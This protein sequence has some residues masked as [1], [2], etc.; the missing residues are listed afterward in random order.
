MS[1]SPFPAGSEERHLYSSAG[2]YHLYGRRTYSSVT[3][4]RRQILF[5]LPRNQ[6]EF[7]SAAPISYRKF[8]RDLEEAIEVNSTIAKAIFTHSIEAFD[9]EESILQGKEWLDI[10]DDNSISK[11]QSMIKQLYRE[12]SA[13]GAVERDACN[14]PVLQ[15]LERRF[16]HLGNDDKEKI[17]ILVPGAGL[18]R[19]AFD[20][21]VAGF[22][23]QGNEN[24][25][26]ALMA[27][28][29]ILNCTKSANQH[30][31]HPWITP[32][33]N[34]RSRKDQLRSVQIPDVHPAT[35]LADASISNRFS[36]GAGDF[37]SSHN[38]IYSFKTF[39]VVATVFFID[40]AW[41]IFDY[42]ETIWNVL[43][44]GGLWINYGPL[45]WHWEGK[46]PP[47]G[48]YSTPEL[49]LEELFEVI[50]A[51]GFKIE[52]RVEG[53]RS[54]YTGS[55]GRSMLCNMWQGEFWTAVKVP[56]PSNSPFPAYSE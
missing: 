8:L 41:N 47:E 38:N 27:S 6:Q 31:L 35:V 5:A 3:N 32:F 17:R 25:F 1:E 10:T 54:E 43:V 36:M 19:L 52:K 33:S 45:L 55:G 26:H 13:E 40:T 18:G 21:A 51:F 46:E 39:E 37:V 34:L 28:Q 2:S 24:S 7:L 15:E 53:E 12:W 49:T 11:A 4:P 30:T 23:S 48:E 29:Y 56:K 20:L 9:L 44:D 22:T 14:G 16:G 50:T 42:L